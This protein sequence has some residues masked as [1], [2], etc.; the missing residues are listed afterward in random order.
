M[1]KMIKKCLPLLLAILLLISVAPIKAYADE[2]LSE[3]QEETSEVFEA[4]TEQEDPSEEVP[5][6]EQPKEETLPSETQDPVE[7]TQED[8]N[9]EE[10]PGEDIPAESE[11]PASEVT[12]EEIPQ[13]AETA[14]TE[15]AEAADAEKIE[16]TQESEEIKQEAEIDGM[17][18]EDVIKL[19]DGVESVIL[20]TDADAP[21]GASVS[22]TSSQVIIHINRVGDDGIAGL[23]RFDADEYYKEDEIHGLSELNESEGTFLGEYQCNSTQEFTFD[24][25]SSIGKDYLYSK[26]YIIQDE[27]ILAG[28][29]YAT[30]IRSVRSV[31][32]FEAQTKKGVIHEDDT[33]YAIADEMGT[34]NTV[35]NYDLAT[36]I[37]R[38]EDAN[39]NPVDN[40]RRNAIKFVSNG[41]T[42]YFNADEVKAM[43]GIILN[44]T[45]RKINVNLVILA[46]QKTMNINTYPLTLTYTLENSKLAGLNTSNPR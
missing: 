40:S 30:E 7:N 44:Y 5:A 20:S 16:E 39:G 2:E 13:E 33:T 8:E 45:R 34:G 19:K 31:P 3:Q 18:E 36:L 4:E 17:M 23:Y 21:V 12:E 43:D 32:R 28:P 22:V 46:W 9:E 35:V 25:Y 41:E 6:E 1:N 37:Y 42:F 26:Y 27:K 14:E 11:E 29:F 15:E 10:L 24:R 38:N